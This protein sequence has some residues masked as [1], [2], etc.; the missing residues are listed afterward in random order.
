MLSFIQVP[1]MIVILEILKMF[2]TLK[3]LLMITWIPSVSKFRTSFK[4]STIPV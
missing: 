3:I 4:N 1:K 2:V